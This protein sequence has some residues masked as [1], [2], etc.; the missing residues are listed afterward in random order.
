MER[1][2]SQRVKDAVANIVLA[3]MEE[4][5]PQ[6]FLFGPVDVEGAESMD[7]EPY[8]LVTIVYDGDLTKLDSA[9]MLGQ[10]GCI[11]P[12][13]ANEGIEEFPV[14]FFSLKSAW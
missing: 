4:H 3:D 14:T 9:R 11:R 8:I 2:I 7:G 5:F 1:A 12:K 10:V 6:G 13:L